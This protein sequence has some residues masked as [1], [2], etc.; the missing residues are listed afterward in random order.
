MNQ[1]PAKFFCRNFFAGVIKGVGFSVGFYLITAFIVYVL[2]Y[3]VK[4][5][6]P[7]IGKYISDIVDIVEANRR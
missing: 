7:L 5:N 3:I 4:L 2:Q 1:I 6:I